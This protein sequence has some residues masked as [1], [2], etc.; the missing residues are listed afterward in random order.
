MNNQEIL[1]KKYEAKE[2][3]ESKSWLEVL[4]PMIEKMIADLDSVQTINP[5]STRKADIEVLGRFYAIKSLQLI[6]RT[7]QGIVDSGTELE[8]LEESEE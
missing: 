1:T 4:K 7:L 8:H 6:E 3:L 5:T 2:I